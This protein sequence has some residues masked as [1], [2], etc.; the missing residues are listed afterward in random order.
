[1]VRH[2]CWLSGNQSRE[3]FWKPEISVTSDGSHSKAN[4]AQVARQLG[5]SIKPLDVCF[6]A[7]P[8]KLSDF[9]EGDYLA[10]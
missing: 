3:R 2:S 7:P 4:L 6:L 8:I 9:S 1:L 5:R 10:R